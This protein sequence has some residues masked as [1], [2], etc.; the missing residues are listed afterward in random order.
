MA[1]ARKKQARKRYSADQKAKILATA[2][3]EKLTA[4]AVEKRFGVKP[5]TYYSWR[6]SAKSG[7][8]AAPAGRRGPGRP[9]RDA[10]IAGSV[11]T[12]VQAKV[13]Q[14]LPRVVQEEVDRYLTEV[15]GRR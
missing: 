12:E 13:R 5:V 10:G 11:R 8:A 4:G 6:K 3:Q 1:K 7:P 9:R 2:N 15:F 14:M